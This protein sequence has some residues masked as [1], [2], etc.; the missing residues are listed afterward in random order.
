M[1][2]T[3]RQGHETPNGAGLPTVEKDGRLYVRDEIALALMLQIA[4]DDKDLLEALAA[5]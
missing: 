3:T 4:D 2:T 1:Q 5:Q